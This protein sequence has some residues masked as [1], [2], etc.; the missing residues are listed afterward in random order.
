MLHINIVDIAMEMQQHYVPTYV[1]VSS[2][3]VV[4][5][6]CWQQENLPGSSHKSP[7]YFFPV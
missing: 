3:S 4:I 6:L 2:A 5:L 1:A 7:Q